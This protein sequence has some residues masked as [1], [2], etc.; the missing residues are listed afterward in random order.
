[1][2]N[3]ELYVCPSSPSNWHNTHQAWIDFDPNF[4]NSTPINY[5]YSEMVGNVSGGCKLANM[6]H[7]SEIAILGDCQSTWIGGY[8]ALSFPERALL[9]RMAYARGGFTCGCPPPVPCPATDDHTVHN[10]GSNVGLADG[11]AKWYAANNCRSISGGGPLRY[12][13]NE[14]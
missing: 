4:D 8:W 11:H 2:K 10:G 13:D 5:G 7:P 1:V 3:T 6:G 14:W 9:R 12:Y